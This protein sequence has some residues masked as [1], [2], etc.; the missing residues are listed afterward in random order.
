M[1]VLLNQTVFFSLPEVRLLLLIYQWSIPYSDQQNTS[2]SQTFIPHS[3]VCW[4]QIR[5]FKRQSRL[6]WLRCTFP[7]TPK[8]VSWCS[9]PPPL[10]GNT[11]STCWFPHAPS[12]CS[13]FL[14]ISCSLSHSCLEFRLNLSFPFP[15]SVSVSF[16]LEAFIHLC[17][18]S[19]LCLGKEIR[20]WV[21]Y[22]YCLWRFV[23]AC[24]FVLI[25]LNYESFFLTWYAI[26]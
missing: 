20:R 2:A 11:T 9:P 10:S 23:H 5:S 26:C 19:I 3:P 13:S 1:E 24:R 7:P 17:R 4:V 6:S 14:V 12:H 16:C 8:P 21:D 22:I 25:V 18:F 15:L